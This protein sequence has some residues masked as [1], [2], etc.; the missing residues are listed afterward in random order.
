MKKVDRSLELIGGIL[1]DQ[2]TKHEYAADV[3]GVLDKVKKQLMVAQHV[4]KLAIR[5]QQYRD[6]NG[7]YQMLKI[8]NRIEMEVEKLPDS[9]WKSD[10]ILW[11]N[12]QRK[13]VVSQSKDVLAEWLQTMRNESKVDCTLGFYIIGGCR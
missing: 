2:N 5:A 12:E 9:K 11:M 6:E 1:K 10:A 4:A 3:C 7:L 13:I 8:V